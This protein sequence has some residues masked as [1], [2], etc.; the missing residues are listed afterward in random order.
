M[1]SG[2]DVSDDV[3]IQI[4][5]QKRNGVTNGRISLLFNCS[6][7]TVQRIWSRYRNTDR[8]SRYPRGG[9]RRCTT[10]REDRRLIIISRRARFS[11]LLELRDE[12]KLFVG[13]DVSKSTARRRLK[14]ARVFSRVAKKKPIVCLRNRQHRVRWA[15][16]IQNW[17]VQDNWSYIVFS[18]ESRFTLNGDDGRVRCWRSAGETFLPDVMS[19]RARSSVSVMVW[20]CIS[21]HGVGEL[22]VVDGRLNHQGYIALLD[23]YLLPSIENMFGDRAH[24]FIFQDD[25]APCHRPRAVDDWLDRN[26]IRRMQWPAQSPDANIIENIWN[27]ISRAVTKDHPT[28]KHALVTSIFRAWAS[29]SAQ[30]VRSL[31]DS[32]PNRM[33]AIIRSRG[34]PTK[35]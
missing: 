28:T 16:R 31:Y 33:N 19:F 24:P 32:L 35:Y 22:A 3:R 10:A 14:A 17:T 13:H 30:R 29:V 9:G 8:T 2:K 34:Y 20:G 7:R 18:D 5:N 4:I 15:R 11:T 23:E 6:V 1:G 27:D 25:N 26:E 12:W 21:I